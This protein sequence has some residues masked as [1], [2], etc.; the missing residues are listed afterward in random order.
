MRVL[1]PPLSTQTERTSGEQAHCT[2]PSESH[3][4][5]HILNR[6][7]L[8]HILSEISSK[9]I[10]LM[11]QASEICTNFKYN[12]VYKISFILFTL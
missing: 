5:L 12:L 6:F 1:F 11:A 9:I 4:E 3:T 7:T 10:F 2:H 8:M